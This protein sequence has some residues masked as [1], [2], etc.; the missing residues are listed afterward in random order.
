MPPVSPDLYFPI[1]ITTREY[2]GHVLLGTELASRGRTVVI[3]HKSQVKRIGRAAARCGVVFYKTTQIPDWADGHHEV[4][5]MD[6]EAGI[7]FR[8]FADF[9][10]RQAIARDSRGCGQFCYGP[11]DHDLLTTEF[12]DLH[13]RIHLTGSP[14]VELWGTSGA[15]FYSAASTRIQ[16]HY[17][18]FVLFTSSGGFAHEKDLEK[19]RAEPGATWD[20][21]D[22]AHHFYLMALHAARSGFT[23]VLRPHPVDS[24]IAWQKTVADVPGIHIDTTYDLAAWTRVARAVVHPGTSTAAFEAVCAGIPAVSTQS[25]AKTNVATDLSHLAHDADHLI[26]LL[27]DAREGRLSTFPSAEARLLLERKLL[28]PLEG[29]TVRIADVLDTAVPF[30]GPSGVRYQ[31]HRFSGIRRRITRRRQPERTLGDHRPRPYKRDPLFLETVER[32]VASCLRIL[33]RTDDVRVRE[34][35]ENCFALSL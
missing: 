21:A 35:D 18:E 4:V 13:H 17:G 20:A 25:K 31:E 11:D 29:A 12:P 27:T 23:V 16:D 30:E 32:D 34:L 8:D 9:R 19:Q 5:G 6:P 2:A 14:R 26:R 22:H 24:W 1:E 3:G 10:L 15:D 33:G 28:H 7:V